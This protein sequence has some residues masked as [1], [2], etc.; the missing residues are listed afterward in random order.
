[1]RGRGGSR[2]GGYYPRSGYGGERGH[3][4]QQGPDQYGHP[5]MVDYHH[6][7]P[8]VVGIPPHHHGVAPMGAGPAG[9]GHYAVPVQQ[10]QQ[11]QQVM[12]AGGGGPAPSRYCAL[13]VVVYSLLR[14]FRVLSF[15]LWFCVGRGFAK[16]VFIDLRLMTWFS[17]PTQNVFILV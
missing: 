6:H 1:M 3:M 17:G 11:Q 13:F 8:S 4:P 9:G 7:D 15:C 10:Q 2:D 16:S 12:A 14:T 5:G